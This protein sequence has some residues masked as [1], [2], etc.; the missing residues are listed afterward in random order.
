MWRRWLFATTPEYEYDKIITQSREAT[1]SIRRRRR[2]RRTNE[3]L[4]PVEDEDGWQL[5]SVSVQGL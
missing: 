2:R 5:I 1:P 4:T 3:S